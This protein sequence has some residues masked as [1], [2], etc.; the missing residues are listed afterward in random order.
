MGGV[1]ED[2]RAKLA[3]LGLVTSRATSAK[4]E[5][6]LNDYLAK[7][8]REGEG[9]T[10]L[11]V[12]QV[13]TDLVGFFTGRGLRGLAQSVAESFKSHYLSRSLAPPTIARRLKMYAVCETSARYCRVMTRAEWMPVLIGEVI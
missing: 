9:S 11:T 3:A 13:I 8:Q 4:L 10:A 7:R 6:F 2:L 12:K 5:P 1:G